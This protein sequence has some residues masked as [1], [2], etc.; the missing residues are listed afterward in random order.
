M[1]RLSWQDISEIVVGKVVTGDL[2]P[3]SVTNDVVAEPYDEVLYHY[4]KGVKDTTRLAELVGLEVMRAVLAAAA[5]NKDLPLD[6]Y[7]LLGRSASRHDAGR[8]MVRIG[9]KLYKGENVEVSEVLNAI[10]KL[11]DNQRRLIPLSELE[12]DYDHWVK[13]G[14]APFD[15]H[16]GGLPKAYPTAIGAP[17]GVGKTSLLARIAID[18]AKAKK[19]VAIFTLEMTNGQLFARMLDLAKMSVA[20]RKRIF[21]CQEIIPIDE[22]VAIASRAAADGLDMVGI[23]FADLVI[24][25]EETEQRMALVYKGAARLCKNL[26]IPV[27]LLS[28]LSRKYRGGVPKLDHLRYSGLAEATCGVVCFIHNPKNIFTDAINE[29][30]ARILPTRKGRGYLVI[31]KSKFGYGDHGAPG[32]IQVPWDGKD[33]WGKGEG[34]WFDLGGI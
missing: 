10:I 16:L 26:E 22:I 5:S 30:E 13:C 4:K 32:A 21:L 19:K 34:K 12:P 29:R 24:L 2:N 23:D 31:A 28:Q 8:T 7:Q 18:M 3:D 9:E 6:W 33:G 17:P 20:V 1:A 15:V 14:Y 27:V 11:D 25:G